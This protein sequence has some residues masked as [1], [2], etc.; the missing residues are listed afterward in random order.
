[1][2]I[3]EITCRYRVRINGVSVECGL[4]ATVDPPQTEPYEVVLASMQIE[5]RNV[6]ALTYESAQKTL[7]ALGGETGTSEDGEVDDKKSPKRHHG[8]M[9][10]RPTVKRVAKRKS[11]PRPTSGRGSETAK[12]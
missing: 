10:R 6:I 5:L 3:S 11:K 4:T 12:T 7:E 1:M 2:P 8:R 9:G